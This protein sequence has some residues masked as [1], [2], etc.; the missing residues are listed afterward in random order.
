MLQR[1]HIIVMSC[2][3]ELSQ[4]VRTII[5]STL[6]ISS[7]NDYFVNSY[8]KHFTEL[9][10]WAVESSFCALQLRVEN[11]KEE[12]NLYKWGTC[13]KHIR[14]FILIKLYLFLE[15][16]ITW[17]SVALRVKLNLCDQWW[18][19]CRLLYIRIMIKMFKN[20]LD[21]LM[22]RFYAVTLDV[23]ELQTYGLFDY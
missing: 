18:E 17:T 8:F 14:N 12:Q 10:Y 1:D 9:W 7:G 19:T 6:Q 22:I 20:Y 15:S 13:D 3:Q 2:S 5:T 11:S 21:S 4:F 23:A 16:F